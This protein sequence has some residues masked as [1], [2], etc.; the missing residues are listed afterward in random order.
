M[1]QVKNKIN[2]LDKAKH[3]I[4]QHGGIIRTAKAIQAGIHPRTLYQ[5]RDGGL[6]E[7][8]SRGVY[9]LTDQ[10][11]VSDPDLVIVATRIPKAVICLVSAL[12]FHEMTTQIPHTVSIALLKGSDTPRLEYPPISIHRFAMEALVAGVT[13]HKIDNVPVKVYSP[14][15]TLVDCF[16][17]RNKIGMDVVLEALKLYKA[18][19]EFKPGEILKYARICRVEKIM[20]PYLEMSI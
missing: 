8:L 14:E 19:K 1:K 17:F 4:R 20:R 9:R 10:E 16:K 3:I 2:A 7:Q 13:V 5:L 12:S 11:A 18:R 6:L 15:K